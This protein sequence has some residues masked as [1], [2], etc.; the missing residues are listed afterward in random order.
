MT[1]EMKL[2]IVADFEVGKRAVNIRHEMGIPLSI[3]DMKW[4]YRLQH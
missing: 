4:E 2:K 1:V 3:S